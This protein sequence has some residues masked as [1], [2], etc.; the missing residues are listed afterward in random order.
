MVG[1]KRDLEG[2]LPPRVMTS[3][4]VHFKIR[5]ANTAISASHDLYM[6]SCQCRYGGWCYSQGR[7]W[8]E[9]CRSWEVE[10]MRLP[11]QG[12]SLQDDYMN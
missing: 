7:G 3:V 5:S 12:R 4:T 10:G 2:S 9:R 8:Y 1:L 6:G 11:W